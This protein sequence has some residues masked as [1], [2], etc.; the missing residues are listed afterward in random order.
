MRDMA[1][2]RAYQNPTELAMKY[3]FFLDSSERS[4]S[5]SISFLRNI[6]SGLD[7]KR[8]SNGSKRI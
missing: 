7:L 5:H 1:E 8:L 6:G 3:A 4:D 2:N